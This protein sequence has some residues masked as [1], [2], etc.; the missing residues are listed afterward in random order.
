MESKFENEI[1][2]SISI[3][4]LQNESLERIQRK[5]NEDEIEIAKKG[6]ESGLSFNFDMVCHTIFSEMIVQ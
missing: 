1:I 5:L 6:L 3:E 2:F 4:D